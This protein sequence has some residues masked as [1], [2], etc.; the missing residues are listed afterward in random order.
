MPLLFTILELSNYVEEI[1][2]QV[3]ADFEILEI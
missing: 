3:K 2:P 1:F